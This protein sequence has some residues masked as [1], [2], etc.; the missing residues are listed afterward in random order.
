[1]HWLPAILILPYLYLLLR[2]CRNLLN[3]RQFNLT[4]EPQTFTSLVIACHNEEQ[5]LTALLNGIAAQNYPRDLFEVIVIDD[6]SS[7]NSQNI[8]SSFTELNNLLLLK[9]EGNGKKQALRTGINA[10]RGELIITTDADCLPG[11]NWIRTIA[12]YYEKYSPE[13]IIM[14]VTTRPVSGFPG[15]FQEMEFL[16]LQGITAGTAI[17]SDPV[18]CNGANLA[19]KKNSYL[20]QKDKLHDEIKSGDDVFLLHSMKEETNSGLLWLESPDAIVTTLPV[21]SPMSFYKQR[22]RWFSKSRAYKDKT[23]IVLGIVTLLAVILQAV[24]CIIA[25][26]NSYFVWVFITVFILKSV[27]DYLL[28]NNTAQRYSRKKLLRWFLPSQLIYPFYVIS[29]VIYSLFSE[30]E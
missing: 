9:N 26:F 18:M 17:M 4:E 1:M 22:G 28:L 8:V 25:V 13:M 20:R 15:R 14:P 6:N 11:K 2:I 16:S 24:L 23:T 21:S 5:N 27:P 10:S 29:V 12:A 3:I 19:F 7:D 30:K